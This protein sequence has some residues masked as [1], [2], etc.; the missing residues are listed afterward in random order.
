MMYTVGEIAKKLNV[1][2]STL[3][4][5]DKEGLLPFVKRSD[6]GMRIFGD[7]DMSS[8]KVIECLK[9]TGMPIKEIKHFMDCCLAG[10]D[11]I[12][13]RLA[14]VKSQRDQV[15]RQMEEQQNMLEM[16]NYKCWYYETAEKAG[17]C[18]V[19]DLIRKEDIPTEFRKFRCDLEEETEEK[20]TCDL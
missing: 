13:E 5:Y 14:I 10:D 17:S 6:G 7:E 4:Y 8:L 1:T 3:R 9:K 12:G 2:A 15:L 18:A 19:H 16:L 20:K 11:K